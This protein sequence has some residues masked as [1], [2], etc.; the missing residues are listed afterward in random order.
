MVDRRVDEAGAALL[1]SRH[2]DRVTVPKGWALDDRRDDS[3]RLFGVGRFNEPKAPRE[4]PREKLRRLPENVAAAL[5]QLAL[6][7]VRSTEPYDLPAGYE[8][9]SAATTH[10][11]HVAATPGPTADAGASDDPPSPKRPSATERALARARERERA[12]ADQSIFTDEELR[13]PLLARAFDA[14][15]S[16]VRTS[17]GLTSLI[18]Q[19][20]AD[21]TDAAPA[22][23]TL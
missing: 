4:T 23:A 7:E 9:T 3:P 2:A 22:T 8:A 13:G 19:L 14:A 6:D 15:R 21:D 18:P 17:S 12:G 10:P 20:G 1:C 5:A 11:E 16:R